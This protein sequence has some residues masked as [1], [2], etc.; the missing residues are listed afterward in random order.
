M[1]TLSEKVFLT[2]TWEQKMYLEEDIKQ[3]IRDIKERCNI[4][5]ADW[6]ILNEIAGDKLI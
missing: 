2:K 5:F 3:F 6:K 4:S 1:K